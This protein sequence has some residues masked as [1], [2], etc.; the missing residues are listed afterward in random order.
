MEVLVDEGEWRT[1]SVI[2]PQGV[3]VVRQVLEGAQCDVREVFE[4][5]GIGVGRGVKQD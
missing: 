2:V 4:E 3:E 5:A 1:D